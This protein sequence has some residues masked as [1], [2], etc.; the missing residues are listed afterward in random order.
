MEVSFFAL[1]FQI[2]CKKTLR[3]EQHQQH[4]HAHIHPPRHLSVKECLASRCLL[5][6]R[7]E[8]DTFIDAAWVMASG[9]EVCSGWVGF[10]DSWVGFIGVLDVCT[11]GWVLVNWCVGGWGRCM[12]GV[13]T[14]AAKSIPPS[15]TSGSGIIFAGSSFYVFY[16]FIYLFT[17]FLSD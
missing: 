17:S 10:T 3:G 12:C 11:R 6:P 14:V 9:C 4:T 2:D 15:N 8:S 1:L 13:C 5:S 16:C 7:L